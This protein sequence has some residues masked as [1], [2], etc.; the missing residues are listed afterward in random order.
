MKKINLLFIVIIIITSCNLNE[1]R[2]VTGNIDASIAG[3][4]LLYKGDG[5]AVM[6]LHLDGMK[7]LMA[8][9]FDIVTLKFNSNHTGNFEADL[10]WMKKDVPFK[11]KEIETNLIRI[12][13][14]EYGKGDMIIFFKYENNILKQIVKFGDEPI[15]SFGENTF[16]E[17]KS[18]QKFHKIANRSSFIK[19]NRI[20]VKDFSKKQNDY[21]KGITTKTGVNVRM[22][23]GTEFYAKGKSDG[24]KEFYI[25]GQKK[26]WWAVIFNTNLPIKT[27]IH[28]DFVK[29]I[30]KGKI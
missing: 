12:K 1:S 19:V 15:N 8:E 20:I 28:K 26:D 6:E 9:D 10:G 27:W 21:P 30:K 11:W 16:K 18:Y 7:H 13:V 22:G 4:Y 24:K 5:A 3:S 25:V 2:N 29:V 14:S 17:K 23:P